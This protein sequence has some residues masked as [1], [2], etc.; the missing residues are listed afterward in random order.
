MENK[1]K[2]NKIKQGKKKYKM[3]VWREKEHQ[4]I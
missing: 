2:T 4:K 1:Q 3:Q